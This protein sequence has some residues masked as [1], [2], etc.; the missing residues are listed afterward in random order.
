[1]WSGVSPLDAVGHAFDG[2]RGPLPSW[3]TPVVAACWPDLP[4]GWT[5]QRVRR[6]LLDPATSSQVRDVVWRVLVEHARSGGAAKVVAA[7][8]ALPGLRRLAVRLGCGRAGEQADVDGEVLAGFLARL[9]DDRFDPAR[10][11]VCGRLMD[12]AWRYAHA[13]VPAS[14]DFVQVRVSPGGPAEPVWPW[15]HPDWV[16][17]RAVLARVIDAREAYVI[18]ATRLE[19]LPLPHAAAM[20]GVHPDLAVRWRRRAEHR[21]RDAITSGAL[22]HAALPDAAVLGRVG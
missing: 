11:R 19:Q 20:A 5:L 4:G 7:G 2:V 8:M 6:M 16:L 21:L 22:H 1:M 14:A 15:G 17:A 13:A 3:L 9:H 10:R 12:A 18:G